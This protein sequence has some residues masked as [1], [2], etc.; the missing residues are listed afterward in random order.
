[1]TTPAARIARLRR[2]N[3]RRRFDPVLAL[4]ALI[5]ALALAGMV[6]HLN[7]AGGADAV[8]DPRR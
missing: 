6:Y 1:M 7:A 5:V 2:Y 4:L 3:S 8:L